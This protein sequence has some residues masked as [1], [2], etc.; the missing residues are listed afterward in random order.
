M[1]GENKNSPA[2]A[3]LLIIAQGSGLEKLWLVMAAF[4]AASSPKIAGFFFA[5][6]GDVD[7]KYTA[8]EILTVEH[9]DCLL[10]FF[11]RGH[12]HKPE[13]FGAACSSIFY[14]RSGC[15]GSSLTEVTL[16]V[17]ISSGVGQIAYI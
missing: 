11:V 16:E 2:S 6:F 7:G 10:G 13:A 3:R 14:Q 8:H 5:G 12:F 4:A 17:I 15:D 1:K 9:T